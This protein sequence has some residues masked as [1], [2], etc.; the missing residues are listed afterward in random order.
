MQRRAFVVSALMFAFALAFAG[1][2]SAATRIA[3]PAT[4]V[5]EV[6]ARLAKGGDYVPP[7]DIYSA[8]L[9]GLWA[10]EARESPKDEVGRIDFLFWINGQ[11]GAPSNVRIKT[12]PVE[13][14][15][16][17]RIETVTFVNDKPQTLQFYFERVGT[18]WK[19]DDVVCTTPGE[20]WTLS[21]ILKYGWAS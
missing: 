1:H 19:L 3:D 5:G 15:T 7:D 10:L 6:Y 17:R 9:A 11:D 20:A 21:V 13:G 18:N 2:A 4:F 12:F 8:H 14:R 16:D